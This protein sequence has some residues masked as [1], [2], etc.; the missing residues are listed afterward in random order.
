MTTQQ[1][2]MTLVFTDI[3]G[4]KIYRNECG[5]LV[6][7]KGRL[8]GLEAEANIRVAIGEWQAAGLIYG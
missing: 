6:D 5:D 2:I 3:D 4:F 8:L 1:A 7:G